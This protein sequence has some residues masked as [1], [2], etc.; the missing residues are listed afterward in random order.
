MQ[1]MKFPHLDLTLEEKQGVRITQNGKSYLT[2][3]W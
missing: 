1:K 3:K 2:D